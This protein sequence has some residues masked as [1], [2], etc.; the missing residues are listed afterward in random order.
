MDEIRNQIGKTPLLIRLHTAM[1]YISAMCRDG[2]PPRMSV[3][4]RSTDEDLFITITL[5][6][7]INRITE[8]ERINADLR[9]VIAG[10]FLPISAESDLQDISF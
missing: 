7:A 10:P 8:L 5:D 4:A 6:D 9:Q 2:R 1:E 3:P